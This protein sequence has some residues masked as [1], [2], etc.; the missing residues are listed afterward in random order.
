VKL[1]DISEKKEEYLK[2]K[3]EELEINR[4][5]KTIRDLFRSISD[6]KVGLPD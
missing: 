6:F 3:I 1:A 5:I 2:A 4:K